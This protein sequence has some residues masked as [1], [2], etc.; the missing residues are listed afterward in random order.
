MPQSSARSGTRSVSSSTS[1]ASHTADHPTSTPSRAESAESPREDR[2]R[3]ETTGDGAR[4]IV[5]GYRMIRA[6]AQVAELGP[7]SMASKVS[8]VQIPSASHHEIPCCDGDLGVS[9]V[10]NQQP[11]PGPKP[12]PT[13]RADSSRAAAAVHR[14]RGRGAHR[15]RAWCG[16]RRAPCALGS[17]SGEDLPGSKAQHVNA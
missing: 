12:T 9:E 11:E 7:S 15:C 16:S 13:P 8:G 1:P 10:L 5:N 2:W 14:G 3:P 4:Q 17:P 6:F